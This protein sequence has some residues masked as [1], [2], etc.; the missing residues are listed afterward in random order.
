MLITNC[1]DFLGTVT[2]ENTTTGGV[3]YD[4][5][6]TEPNGQLAQY[7]LRS[8]WQKDDLT[9][10]IYSFTSDIDQET[11]RQIFRQAFDTWSSVTPL[12]FTEVNTA[13]EAD[14]IIGFGWGRHCELY[15]ASG[16]PCGPDPGF[17]APMG[18][19]AHCYFPGQGNISGDAHFDENE[20]WGQNSES[21][22]ISLLSTAIHELGHGL[23]LE[24]SQ[25]PN[26]IMY[27]QYNPNNPKTTLSNDDIA[28]IQALYGPRDGQPPPPP[29]P[30]DDPPDVSPCGN[31]T[32]YDS[33][34]DGLQNST[35]LYLVGTN[36]NDCDTDGDNLPDS[37]IYWG[38]NPLNPDTDGDGA[39]DYEEINNGTNPLV[40]DQGGAG[41]SIVG[42]YVGQDSFG[43]PF[44]FVLYPNGN[45]EG[46]LRI[47]YFGVPTDI[48]L[49][50]GIDAAGQLVLVSYDYFFTYYGSFGNGFAQGQFQT[51]AGAVGT[52]YTTKYSQ[53]QIDD[54][55]LPA[56]VE[57]NAYHPVNEKQQ[58]LTHPV[59]Y[60]TDWK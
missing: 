4:N 32:E 59:Y 7:R 21:G 25:D 29:A 40:P 24:H 37:E 9:Y 54:L 33:D 45:A 3:F 50:G 17:D 15:Q 12:N 6:P 39:S 1:D 42:T 18:I 8:R 16:A 10:V 52:W 27:G 56:A 60:R 36:P 47:L 44:Q 30:S 19:L 41:G 5:L 2:D 11:Q 20:F 38:L 48:Y 28:A 43:S 51:R 49:I 58:K 31:P 34:G 13:G 53:T 35:E 55:E 57:S 22:K 46:I 26:A 23:G 14:I